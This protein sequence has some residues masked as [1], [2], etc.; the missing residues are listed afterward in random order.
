MIKIKT[1]RLFEKSD[2]TFFTEEEKI[3]IEDICQDL[4][5]SGFTIVINSGRIKINKEDYIG[6]E[7]IFT[8][9]E[10]IFETIKRLE[11]YLDRSW[12]EVSVVLSGEI[13]T[14]KI[15]MDESSHRC[16]LMSDKESRYTEKLLGGSMT[17]I[18]R[19]F[20]EI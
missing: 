13:D 15:Y 5:D 9:T 2:E 10:E 7:V 16:F 20:I 14:R 12:F 19:L 17:R 11:D 4:K 18:K 8:L 6:A 1:F 3:E